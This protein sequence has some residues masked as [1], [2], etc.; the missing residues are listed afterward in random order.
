ME[1]KLDPGSETNIQDN[2][3]DSLETVFVLKIL[4]FCDADPDLDLFDPGSGMEKFGSGI[5]YKHPGSAAL[6][7]LCRG[8]AYFHMNYFNLLKN[9]ISVTPIDQSHRLL[10]NSRDFLSPFFHSQFCIFCFVTLLRGFSYTFYGFQYFILLS[11]NKWK[12]FFSRF[13]YVFFF[14]SQFY[15]LCNVS[16]YFMV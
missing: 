15:I 16:Y 2:F 3:S 11:I 6:I 7:I 10:I 5:W 12:I 9:L 14:S 4:K 8:F 13:F 1:K